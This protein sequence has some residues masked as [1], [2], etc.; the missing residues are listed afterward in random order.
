MSIISILLAASAPT[1]PNAMPAEMV[2]SLVEVVT[3]RDDPLEPSILLHT[4][5]LAKDKQP[6]ADEIQDYFFSLSEDRK[7]KQ[8]TYFISVYRLY[9]DRSIRFYT[10]F[11]YIG[12]DGPVQLPIVF[13][14]RKVSKC[15]GQL[16]MCT[17]QEAFTLKIPENDF[18]ALANAQEDLKPWEF[19]YTGKS[20]AESRYIMM[21]VEAKALLRKADLVSIK[22]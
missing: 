21:P 3:V 16:N 12:A 7:T 13:A 18:L 5:N 8:R 22:K 17:F 19:K 4:K 15:F 14:D 10:V 9:L 6:S 20:G 1:V 11:N 2:D